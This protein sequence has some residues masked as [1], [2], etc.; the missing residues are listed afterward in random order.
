VSS[1]IPLQR[2]NQAATPATGGSGGAVPLVPTKIRSPAPRASR[3]PRARLEGQLADATDRKLTVLRA[4]GGFGK[5]T[6][7]LC[8]IE[9]LRSRGDAVAWLSIDGDDNEP[10]R[11]IYYVIQALHRACPDIGKESLK[12]ANSATLQ[13]LQALLVG[14]IADCGDELFL[15]L[16]D[17]NT[18]SHEAIHAFVA[19]LLRHAPANLRVV[20]M[21]RSEPPLELGALRARGELLEIDAARLRFT[22]DETG[23][24]LGATAPAGLELEE[25][26]TIHRLTE[27]WPAALRITA[28]S[29]GAGRDPAELLRSLTRSP[30][31][32]G[33]YMDELLSLLPSDLL[34]FMERTAIVD[35]LS[36]SLCDAITGRPDGDV[37]LDRL[38]RQQLV[39]RL[40]EEGDLYACHQLFREHL[41]QRLE[42]HHGEEVAELHRRASRWYEARG[43]ETETVKHLL[44]AG[45][46]GAALVRITQCAGRMVESGDLLT[47]L[48]WERQ[49]RSKSI[50]Q[51]ITLQLAII[52]AE[53]L[54]LSSAEAARHI[55]A[56][57]RAVQE[58]DAGDAAAIRRE[59]VA[60]RA[61]ASGLADDPVAAAGW[62]SRYAAQADD[63]LIARG[64]VDN[65]ARSVHLWN[66]RWSNFYAVPPIAGLDPADVLPATYEANLR[67]IAELAQARAGPAEQAFLRS[68]EVGRQAR[69]FA[70]ATGMAKGPYSELLYETGRTDEAESL[71]RDQID[72]VANGVVLDS[73]L[74][75]LLTAAR[76]AARR[77]QAEQA[78]SLL[79][80]AEVVGLTRE[81][82]RLVAAALLGRLRLQLR[83]GVPSSA[84]G[85]LKRLQQLHEAGTAAVTRGIEGVS[86]YHAMGQAVLSIDQQRPRQAVA[87]L[88]PVFEDA[89]ACGASL[90][91][92]RAGTILARA[93]VRARGVAQG[94]RVFDQ[95]LRIATPSSFVGSMADEGA[96]IVELLDLVEAGGTRPDLEDRRLFIRKLRDSLSGTVAGAAGPSS[97]ATRGLQSP[98]SP[99]EREILELIAE[100]QSNKAIARQ[101]GLGPETVKTHLKN[102]FAKLGVER[103]TQAVLRADE[104]GV[105]RNRRS[106][107]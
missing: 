79:E 7:A 21:S 48:N 56:V 107:R 46:T 71:L 15:F 99:R 35:R 73:V 29:F 39:T 47:L 105:L 76:L 57:E 81:W 32:I 11:F 3:I 24:F 106:P 101:L 84:L 9:E 90:I 19:F 37:M 68:L 103:R 60:L 38:D 66:A 89:V 96:E 82:P 44:A 94:L 64:S 88:T 28:L 12:S 58:S 45:D 36:A 83:Q 93:H 4:P 80:R 53:A 65:V 74:R 34:E 104:L 13:Q 16:D 62:V 77:G 10:R 50:Q 59:C 52:W 97:S 5:T 61:V 63:R 91:A 86:H 14:E 100:G 40:D 23:A 43:L 75:G 67:G 87:T 85:L 54:S 25:V 30:T 41:L 72:L 31:S 51:P 102:I 70:G 55:E 98:L 26:R 1:V 17:Y 42:R 8:W 33:G 22:C 18:V 78:G 69:R 20:L 92:I 95:V 6:L 49:L 2:N 27:G